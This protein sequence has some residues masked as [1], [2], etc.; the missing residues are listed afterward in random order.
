[1]LLQKAI[2]MGLWISDVIDVLCTPVVV[3]VMVMMAFRNMMVMATV[4]VLT[5]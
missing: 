1:M 4:V 3:V 2:Q 5:T